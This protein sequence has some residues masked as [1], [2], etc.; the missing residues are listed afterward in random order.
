VASPIEWSGHRPKLTSL[1]NEFFGLP[2]EL[3]G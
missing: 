3:T 1:Q 2:A